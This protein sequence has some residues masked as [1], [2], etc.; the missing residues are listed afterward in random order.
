MANGKESITT[1]LHIEFIIWRVGTGSANTSLHFMLLLLLLFL[2][3]HLPM[4]NCARNTVF[5]SLSFETATQCEG[6]CWKYNK[7]A[8]KQ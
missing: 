8:Q 4:P 5:S 6:D 3:A 7:H 2:V 1:V